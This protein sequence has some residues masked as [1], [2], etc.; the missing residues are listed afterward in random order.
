MAL[1]C[2]TV[3]CLT[4]VLL[5]ICSALSDP[6]IASAA[7][8]AAPSSSGDA[9]TTS[10]D[11]SLAL[12]YSYR[13]AKTGTDRA[14]DQDAF[15]ELRLDMTQPNEGRHEFHFFGALRSDLDGNQDHTSFYPL[16]DIYDTYGRATVGTVY[17]AYYA[18]NRPFRPLT[19]MRAGRQAGTRDEPVFFD[20]LA[21]DLGTD[22]LNVTVYGGA[23]VHFYEVG[24]HWGNDTLGGAG[25]DFRP[26]DGLGLSADWLAV[27]DEREW[28]PSG[29]MLRDRMAA[30]K[31]R[32]QFDT[33]AQ[34]TLKYRVLN[35][36]PRDLSIAALAAFPAWDAETTVRYLRQ[37]RVQDELATDLSPYTEVIGQSSPF[38]SVDVTVR[39]T[40]AERITL[41]GGYFS[42][43]L[44]HPA[45]EGPFDKE[46][47]KMFLAADIADLFVAGLS[48]TMTA[49]QW[50]SLSTDTH[51]Y[52]IDITYRIKRHGTTARFGAG[53][54]YSLYKYDYYTELG[55]RD[56]VR[57]YYI[58]A[59]YPLARAVS[60][61]GRYEFERGIEEYQ[62]LRLGM[63]YAF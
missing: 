49:E 40:I 36:D 52:G 38:Q 30:F 54:Y 46:Y 51:T 26:R 9:A 44:L 20:G 18:L 53:T 13:S 4:I 42:R 62:I 50:E 8:D 33:F 59:K 31:V 61:D 23:A 37:F 60:V 28:D 48:L 63:R 11:G 15:A 5:S 35:G 1:R 41:D 19:Q 43:T 57:T 3:R 55:V 47:S 32:Q 16:E 58:E 29:G 6:L 39:K 10:I 25:I 14:T 21:A 34:Y 24:Q 2:R 12:R 45:D 7:D 27:S 56:K 17:E 22:I